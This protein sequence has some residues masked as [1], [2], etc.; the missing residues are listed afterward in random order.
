MIKT[1]LT[2]EDAI[3][4][5]LHLNLGLNAPRSMRMG[6]VTVLLFVGMAL[7]SVLM[8]IVMIRTLDVTQ[9]AEEISLSILVKLL[10]RMELT[11]QY[12]LL[13]AETGRLFLMKHVMTGLMIT[14]DVIQLAQE[15][16]KDSIVQVPE[17]MEA[18]IVSLSVG[19][20]C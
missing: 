8:K 9:I 2:N 17:Q 3:L 19:I 15:K 4:I 18:A 7:S 11:L 12:V 13:S 14:E 20:T 10:K 6:Q 5:V 16:F 1:Q